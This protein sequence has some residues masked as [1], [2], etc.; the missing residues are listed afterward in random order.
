[1]DVLNDIQTVRVRAWVEIAKR[2]NLVGHDVT[3]VI[4]HDVWSAEFTHNGS[5]NFLVGLPANTDGYLIL[6]V[7]LALRVDVN[8]NNPGTW[9]EILFPKLKRQGC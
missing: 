5:E 9:T 7:G 6:L 4:E 2:L 3:A 1:M 8:A